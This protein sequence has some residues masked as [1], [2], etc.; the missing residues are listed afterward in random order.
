ML[1]NKLRLFYSNCNNCRS[2]IFF[3]CSSCVG[4][5][6]RFFVYNKKSSRK[7]KQRIHDPLDAQCTSFCGNRVRDFSFTHIFDEFFGLE[8]IQ[9]SETVRRQTNLPFSFCFYFCFLIFTFRVSVHVKYSFDSRHRCQYNIEILKYCFPSS[10][11]KQAFR[12]DD[13]F[14]TVFFRRFR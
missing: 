9:I 11:A 10:V 8:P 6:L 1:A 7:T 4:F 3:F 5:L 14:S 12:C 13:F 2:K